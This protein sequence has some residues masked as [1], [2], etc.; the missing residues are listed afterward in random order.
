MLV[1]FSAWRRRST[2]PLVQLRIKV[3]LARPTRVC[4]LFSVC[5]C[6]STLWPQRRVWRALPH[7][8]ARPSHISADGRH[9]S[10]IGSPAHWVLAASFFVCLVCPRMPGWLE[11]YRAKGRENWTPNRSIETGNTSDTSVAM[12]VAHMTRVAKSPRHRWKPVR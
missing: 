2:R 11:K 5:F 10:R 12:E 3:P 4:L 9:A 6:D 1:R 7:G 8:H